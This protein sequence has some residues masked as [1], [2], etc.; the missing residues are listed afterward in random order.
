LKLVTLSKVKVDRLEL[1]RIIFKILG[2]NNNDLLAL[3]RGVVEL[4]VSRLKRVASARKKKKKNEVNPTAIAESIIKRINFNRRFPE[5]YIASY[6]GPWIEELK[7][8]K[9][10]N[11]VLG[12]DLGGFYVKIDE[13][14]VYRSWKS[15]IAKYIYYALL[16]GNSI[17]RIPKNEEV[18]KEAVE[19][20][21]EDLGKLKEEVNKLLELAIPDT[22]IRSEV[23][24]VVW[25]RLLKSRKEG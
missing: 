15:H 2:L 18:V 6:K 19:L 10:S 24:S 1:D 17:V 22:K 13:R 21:E 3:Y 14:E 8:P 23:E 20:F 16:C 4:I 12:T 11:V 5:D 7:L 25:K 9:G